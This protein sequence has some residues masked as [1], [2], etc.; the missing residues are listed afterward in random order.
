MIKGILVFLLCAVKG[1]LTFVLFRM[2]DCDVKQKE[3]R[4]EY[5]GMRC[6]QNGGPK[7][8]FPLRFYSYNCNCPYEHLSEA[9]LMIEKLEVEVSSIGQDT[10]FVL[11]LCLSPGE[12]ASIPGCTL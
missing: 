3:A 7:T 1:W 5:Q 8:L 4:A 2:A 6:V 11:F 12:G 10:V 9:N